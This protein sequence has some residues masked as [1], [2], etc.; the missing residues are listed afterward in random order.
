MTWIFMHDVD[1]IQT[2]F[3]KFVRE[4]EDGEDSGE[5]MPHFYDGI[6]LNALF[7]TGK[8]RE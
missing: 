4:T 8:D 7:L 1:P 5:R 6:C 3:V 2:S